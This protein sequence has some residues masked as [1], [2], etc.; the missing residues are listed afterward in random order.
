MSSRKFE[1]GNDKR[2]RC[3]DALIESQRGS[4]EK[5]NKS[6]T[7]TARNPD[8]WAIVVVDEI[9]I[10]AIINDFAAVNVRRKF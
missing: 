7:S 10:E 3:V 5:K 6:N 1:S 2:K 8:E 4:I 9:D